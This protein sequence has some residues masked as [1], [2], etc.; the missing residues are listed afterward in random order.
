MR[1]HR[2]QRATGALKSDALPISRGSRN[3]AFRSSAFRALSKFGGSVQLHLV[4]ELSGCPW[5]LVRF[6]V[7]FFFQCK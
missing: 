4:D 5:A 1:N 3:T 2:F 7:D 6:G